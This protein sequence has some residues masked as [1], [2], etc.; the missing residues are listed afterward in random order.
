MLHKL[1][2][3]AAIGKYR[4]RCMQIYFHLANNFLL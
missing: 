2:L 1:N 3:D 4:N